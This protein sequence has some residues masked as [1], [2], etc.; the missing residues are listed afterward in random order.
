MAAPLPR[1]KPENAVSYV[2]RGSVVV[3]RTGPPPVM[4]KN[5]TNIWKFDTMEV[6]VTVFTTGMMHG[7]VM[8]QNFCAPVAPS[9]SAASFRSSGTVCS[10]E[11]SIIIINGICFHT[12]EMITPSIAVFGLPRTL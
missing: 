8:H 1:L 11:R 6:S 4:V 12:A 10:P 3:A 2:Y 5:R 9:I 7:T